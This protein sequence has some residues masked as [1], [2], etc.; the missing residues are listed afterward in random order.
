MHIGALLILSLWA[1]CAWGQET[2]T[3][4]VSL[5]WV[6]PGDDGT[7]GTAREYDLRYSTKPIDSRNW[8]LAISVAG[9][10]IPQ[11]SGVIQSYTLSGLSADTRYY[12]AL[13][14]RDEAWNWSPLSNVLYIEP[15]SL[16]ILLIR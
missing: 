13:R 4:S 8:H 2:K 1:T 14:A 9:E 16:G 3:R 10:P 12:I 7:I 11:P 5:S 6:A 15:E